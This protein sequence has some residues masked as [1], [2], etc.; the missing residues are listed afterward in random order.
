MNSTSN[1][2]A[3]PVSRPLRL[4]VF[5]DRWDQPAWVS[6]ILESLAARPDLCEIALVVKG[7]LPPSSR[8]RGQFLYRVYSRVDHL[9]FGR[10]AHALRRSDVRQGLG[11]VDTIEVVP[12]RTRYSD[13]FEAEDVQRVRDQRIDVGLR[14]GFRIMRGEILEACRFGIWSYHHGD[15]QRF[16]GGPPGFWEVFENHSTTGSVLQRLSEELDG[17]V[18]LQRSYAATNRTSVIRS[19]DNYYRKSAAFVVRALEE[20]MNGGA[21]T[22]DAPDPSRSPRVYSHALYRPPSNRQM[23]RIV[24]RHV[25]RRLGDRLLRMWARERWMIGICKMSSSGDIALYRLKTLTPPQD[26]FWADPFPLRFDGRLFIFVEE[27][28]LDGDRGH[29]AVLEVDEQD[30]RVVEHRVVLR[31]GHHLSYP[32]VFE[33]DG[34]HHLVPEASESGRVVAYRAIDF[35]WSWE[36]DRVVIDTGLVDP[37]LIDHNGSWWLFGTLPYRGASA[38]DELHAFHG[39]SPF[40]PWE[41]HPEN[42]VRSDVQGA[43]PAGG[44]FR[45]GERLY[46]PGQDCSERYGGGIILHEVDLDTDHYA[47]QPAAHMYPEWSTKVR[48]M[49]TFNTSGDLAVV[50]LAVAESWWSRVRRRVKS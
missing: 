48:G 26:V 1:V 49:H 30:A 43:R 33:H 27:Y 11:D 4:A 45:R 2:A 24:P 44:L 5:L 29:I 6:Y 3:M 10:G 22:L 14:F 37:T 39:P 20:L 7:D 40:G 47:E 9:V 18:V 46:R 41:A 19:Q 15:D 42:P 36:P 50:D 34:E 21:R 38:N 16:R 13:Y 17:G 35:P 28:P 32:F 23:L 12:R 25:V 31:E 8:T